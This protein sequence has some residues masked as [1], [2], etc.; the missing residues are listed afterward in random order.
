MLVSISA[1]YI[2]VSGAF[3]HGVKDKSNE[4][5]LQCYVQDLHKIKVPQKPRRYVVI[6]SLS[7]QKGLDACF[8]HS[9]PDMRPIPGLEGRSFPSTWE[10]FCCPEITTSRKRVLLFMVCPLT[11]FTWYA[12]QFSE[13]PCV[14][15]AWLEKNH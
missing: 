3:P 12:K 7:L 13:S 9:T 11:L 6:T 8:L 10:H 4:F 2:I 15:L 5:R 14:F 1:H